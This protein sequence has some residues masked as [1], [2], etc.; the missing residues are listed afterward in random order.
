MTNDSW[1][2][3]GLTGIIEQLCVSKSKG[4]VKSPVDGTMNLV[5]ES[6]IEGDAHA[7]PGPRQVSL[8]AAEAVDAFVAAAETRAS[9]IEITAGDAG[10]LVPHRKPGVQQN[11]PIRK[12]VTPGA[13][14]ENI[15]TRGLDHSALV[16]GDRL[17]LGGGGILEVTMIGKHCHNHECA[18]KKATGE[19]L[20]PKTGIFCRVVAG[21]PVSRGVSVEIVKFQKDA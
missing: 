4:T 14:A 5:I 2:S 6:G 16:P 12:I 17:I 20:M 1:N 8:L 21:G 9:L 11:R 18:I 7:E 10:K 19:C 3:A 15:L 13:F